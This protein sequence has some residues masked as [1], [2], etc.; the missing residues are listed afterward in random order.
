MVVFARHDL[1]YA[2]GVARLAKAMKPGKAMGKQPGNPKAPEIV[3]MV[4]KPKKPGVPL[5]GKV[6]AK[7]KPTW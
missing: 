3:L 2:F 6:P 7:G 4:G 5:G 1:E